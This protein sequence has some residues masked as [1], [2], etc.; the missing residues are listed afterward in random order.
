MSPEEGRFNV[1]Q[2]LQE[3]RQSQD[4]E[5]ALARLEIRAKVHDDSSGM[6]KDAHY[7]AANAMILYVDLPGKE[8]ETRIRELL[9]EAID[10]VGI[11]TEDVLKVPNPLKYKIKSSQGNESLMISEEVAINLENKSLAS[12]TG[13]DEIP[14]TT[15]L[16]VL[17]QLTPVNPFDKT[18]DDVIQ[19]SLESNS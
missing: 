19:E 2:A 17:P 11:S 13:N 6:L 16:S 3:K 14:P 10:R 1:Y 8:S 15:P 4:H 7:I 12:S 5:A 9:C 18:K